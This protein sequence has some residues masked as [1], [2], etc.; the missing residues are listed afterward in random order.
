MGVLNMPNCSDCACGGCPYWDPEDEVPVCIVASLDSVVNVDPDDFP[1][2]C[3]MCCPELNKNYYLKTGVSQTAQCEWV[4][5]QCSGTPGDTTNPC[6]SALQAFEA[7]RMVLSQSGADYILTATTRNSLS[8][9]ADICVTWSANLG[10]TPPTQASIAGQILAFVSQCG[11]S[12]EFCDFSGSQITINVSDDVD[13]DNY[14]DTCED[15]EEL[16]RGCWTTLPEAVDVDFGAGGWTDGTCGNCDAITGVFQ[17]TDAITNDLGGCE[18]GTRGQHWG[19]LDESF[20]GPRTLSISACLDDCCAIEVWIYVQ[21][22][23]FIS[24]AKYRAERL[25]TECEPFDG[26]YTLDKYDE[27]HTGGGSAPC[28]GTLPATITI[29]AA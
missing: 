23:A 7:L 1:D 2:S 19:Y 26:P 11:D 3:C 21:S 15:A 16:L 22:G 4:G 13:C 18:G 12:E 14:D 27:S 10:T 28:G 9:T 8:P 17:L 20:C 29:E 24:R 25:E 5:G 6:L